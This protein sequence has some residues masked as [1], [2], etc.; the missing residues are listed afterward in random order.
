MDTLLKPGHP[1]LEDKMTKVRKDIALKGCA[2]QSFLAG[3][4]SEVGLRQRLGVW[5]GEG[6]S[7]KLLPLCGFFMRWKSHHKHAPA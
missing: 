3:L 5:A 4:A 6:Y 1:G 2:Q 7:G